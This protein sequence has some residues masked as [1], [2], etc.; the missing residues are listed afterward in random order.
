MRTGQH[1]SRA[2]EK[3]FKTTQVNMGDLKRTPQSILKKRRG[4]YGDG[5][6]VGSPLDS[7][8]KLTLVSAERSRLK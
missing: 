2:Q 6:A 3:G 8:Y 5:S 4:D 1:Y 7:K